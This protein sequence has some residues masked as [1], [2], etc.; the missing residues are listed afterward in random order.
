MFQGKPFSMGLAVTRRLYDI[1]PIA[2]FRD[3]KAS[4]STPFPGSK[5]P[6]TNMSSPAGQMD[7]IQTQP[8][9][10]ILSLGCPKT[11]VD[12]E[13]ILGL[14]D[15]NRYRIA[16]HISDCDI[17]V[18]NTC[19]FIQD[20]KQESIDHILRLSE[21]KREGRIKALVVLGCLVQ[22]YQKELEKELKEVDA[23]VGTGDY[24]ALNQ[25]LDQ[26]VR[27]KRISQVG[28]VPGFLYTAALERVPLTPRF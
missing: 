12:S 10:G 16:D 11:L 20:A 15:R 9:V 8:S 14:L 17:A 22:R 21:L 19:T 28:H 3:L 2:C 18:L 26:V 1:W 7:T 24:E 6:K 27:R 4:Y 5:S 13:L 25:V 23:F